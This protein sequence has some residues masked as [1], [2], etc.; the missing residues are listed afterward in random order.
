MPTVTRLTAAAVSAVCLA[1]FGAAGCGETGEA[2]AAPLSRDDLITETA[3]QLAA[4]A[5]LA[6][7][8]KYQIAGGDTAMV[9]RAQRPLRAEWVY[10]GGR[11]IVTSTVTITCRQSKCESTAADPAAAA[12]LDEGPLV[13]A[14]A[15]QAMLA[16]AALDPTV[17][18]AQHDTTIAG[19]HAT[20]LTL[21]GVDGTPA[22][23][24]DLCV[25]NEGVLAS[26]TATVDGTRIDQA[27]TSYREDLPDDAFLIP[28]G[29]ELID[30]STK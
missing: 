14:E 29:A 7:S 6:Y 18:T 23:S 22:R 19:R 3:T 24:F 30:K 16:T 27:L 21:S 4:G 15:V 11:L 9:N 8:A 25:T 5:A 13:S 28:P 17:E 2:S 10:P 12:T 20:C 1:L 26:F